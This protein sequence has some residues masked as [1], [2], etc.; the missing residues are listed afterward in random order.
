MPPR[1]AYGQIASRP[2]AQG[3]VVA[4]PL[5]R[6]DERSLKSKGIYGDRAPSLQLQ[7]YFFAKRPRLSERRFAGTNSPSL[8]T[9]FPSK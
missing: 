3:L 6:R 2:V 7:N 9:S 4:T 8:R 5:C 1:F